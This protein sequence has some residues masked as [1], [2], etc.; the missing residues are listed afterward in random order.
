MDINSIQGYN[1]NAGFADNQGVI[2]TGGEH[3]YVVDYGKPIG[4]DYTE[5]E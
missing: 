3:T 5:H 1:S 2:Y 4:C